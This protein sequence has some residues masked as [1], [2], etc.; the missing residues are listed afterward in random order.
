M[1]WVI[2]EEFESKDIC[3]WFVCL[4]V[5]SIVCLLYKIKKM[6]SEIIEDLSGGTTVQKLVKTQTKDF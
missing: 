4:L 1:H 5:V 3:V 6:A 2:N